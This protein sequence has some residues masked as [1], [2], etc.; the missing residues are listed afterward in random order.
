VGS[1]HRLRVIRCGD[2]AI[3]VD[4]SA[5]R[6]VRFHDL[7]HT[8]GSLAINVASIVQ[9]QAWMGHADIKTT[10]RYAHLESTD[11]SGRARDVMNRINIV[12]VAADQTR[13][14]P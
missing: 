7:R 13:G 3:H 6:R 12:R 4:G 14:C 11:V 2:R 1:F 10:M 8:F 5:L 9:V